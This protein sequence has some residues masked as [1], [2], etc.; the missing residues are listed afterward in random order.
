[1]DDIE[2]EVTYWQTA[3]VC[4]ILGANPPPVVV[5][6]FVNRIWKKF[7]YDKVSFLP[8]GLFIV[9][10]PSEEAQR[11]VLQGGFHLFDN[12]PLII[13]PW[14]PNLDMIKA[15]VTK[16]PVWLRLYRVHLK[17]WGVNCLTKIASEIGKVL[18]LDDRTIQKT[19]LDYARVL[20]EMEV[21]QDLKCEIELENEFDTV[22][23]IMVECE[24]KPVSC[25][26]S[27]GY[28]HQEKDCRRKVEPGVK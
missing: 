2:Q 4:Y 13:Q 1:M 27:Q 9:H 12:K 6:G 16:V 24:W 18:K 10:F 28:G 19:H 23:Y 3:V 21:N 26:Y 17:Y 20:V 15:P 7:G 14:S 22:D 5:S 11:Q 8:N 25:A